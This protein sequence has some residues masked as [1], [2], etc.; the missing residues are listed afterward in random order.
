MNASLRDILAA[1]KAHVWH[2]YTPMDEW[3]ARHDPL[4]VERAEGPYFQ[5]AD[6]TRLTST[7]GYRDSMRRLLGKTA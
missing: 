4:V 6:G 5:L 3:R 7:R 1:D 2:P